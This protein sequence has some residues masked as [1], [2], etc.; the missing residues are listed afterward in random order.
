MLIVNLVLYRFVPFALVTQRT[1]LLVVVIRYEAPLLLL[2]PEISGDAV[3][4]T[5]RLVLFAFSP[6]MLWLWTR[7][8]PLPNMSQSNS[9]QNKALLSELSPRSEY[10]HSMFAAIIYSFSWCSKFILI[11]VCKC[12]N[13]GLICVLLD[14]WIVSNAEERGEFGKKESF[15]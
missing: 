12:E 11:C 2:S 9:N 5:K 15:R 14:A 4:N 13:G 8:S 10:R 6:D 7:S 1:W 3:I